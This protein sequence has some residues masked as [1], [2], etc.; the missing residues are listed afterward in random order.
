MKRP[1]LI[2]V[3]AVVAAGAL[4]AAPAV[5]GLAGNRSFSEQLPVRP[6]AHARVLDLRSPTAPAIPSRTAHEV[7]SVAPGADHSRSRDD[8]RGVQPPD[9]RRQS[10]STADRRESG[11]TDDHSRDPDR[12]S[13]DRQVRPGASAQ[14]EDDRGRADRQRSDDRH[15]SDDRH[16][17]RGADDRR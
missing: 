13:D 5:L 11:S 6:P 3:A 10:T 16:R 17:G 8:R 1:P 7:T 14:P 9:D 15:L 2:G 12:A 4:A